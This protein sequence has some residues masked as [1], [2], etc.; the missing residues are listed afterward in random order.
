LAVAGEDSTIKI[1]K[2]AGP[3]DFKSAFQQVVKF[4]GGHFAP[5]NCVDISPSKTMVVSSGN[6]CQ[7][8]VWDLRTKKLAKKLTF[9]DK[10]FRD[11]RGQADPTNFT[12]RGCL[13]S[14]CGRYVYLLASK[15]RYKTFIVQYGADFQPVSVLDVH[16]HA[17]SGLSINPMNGLLTVM[18]SDGWIKCVQ[19]N[20]VVLSQ[21]RHNLPVTCTAFLDESHIFTGSA[22]Y[23]YNMIKLPQSNLVGK[24]ITNLIWILVI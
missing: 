1:Y 2:V 13:F 15:I 9:R 10:S 20:K 6:D 23:T 5:V 18:T 24:S 16:E 22:D 21:K 19:N 17:S 12:I 14:V 7:A 8:C 4:E 3:T 11:M